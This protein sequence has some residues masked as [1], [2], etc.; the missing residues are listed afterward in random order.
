MSRPGASPAAALLPDGALALEVMPAAEAWVADWRPRASFGVPGGSGAR[1]TVTVADD[2]AAPP[3]FSAGPE[4]RVLRLGGAEL[5]AAGQGDWV[6]RTAAG[7][8]GRVPGRSGGGRTEHGARIRVP[9]GE[10]DEV[11]RW[12]A[13]SALTLAAALLLARMGRS[14]IH[15]G[16]VVDPEGRAW[17]LPGDTHSG[18]TT[19][20]TS[21]LDRGWGL[22]SDDQAVV[23]HDG[24]AIRATGWVRPFH[25]DAGWA[26][27]RITGERESV[28]PAA[29]APDATLADAPLAGVLLPEVVAD[30]PTAAAHASQGA[31]VEALVRQSPW[32]MVD[33]DIGAPLLALFR[34]LATGPRHRLRLGRDSYARPRRLEAVVAAAIGS[35]AGGPARPGPRRTPTVGNP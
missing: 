4:N 29:L 1:I 23:W 19:V 12:E 32:L 33:P 16:A 2:D 7:V 15:A 11:R 20:C 24:G 35:E 14:L 22:L 27:R 26:E 25:L 30:A 8:R 31:V 34:A 18:K 28:D 5:F 10:P 17:L 13:F 6:L 21:L 9:A 3:S